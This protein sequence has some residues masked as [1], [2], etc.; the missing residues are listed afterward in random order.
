MRRRGPIVVGAPPE[1]SMAV[2]VVLMQLAFVVV[3]VGAV[4]LFG[5]PGLIVGALTGV[6]LAFVAIV[7]LTADGLM[8]QKKG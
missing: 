4:A 5:Y 1:I 8:P 7:T 3:L 2:L 6:A